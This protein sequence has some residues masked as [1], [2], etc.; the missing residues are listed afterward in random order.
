MKRIIRKEESLCCRIFS[1]A[2]YRQFYET[3]DLLL[4]KSWTF[5]TYEIVVKTI[6]IA[7]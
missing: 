5:T 4:K 3:M 6:H 7:K 2:I 1:D